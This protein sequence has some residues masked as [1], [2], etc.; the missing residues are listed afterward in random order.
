ML[1][2][3]TVSFSRSVL[4]IAIISLLSGCGG[5]SRLDP[6]SFLS[7]DHDDFSNA[8]L[9]IV[10]ESAVKKMRDFDESA[11]FLKIKQDYE[12]I[13]D[14][15]QNS[16][17]KLT[18]QQIKQLPEAFSVIGLNEEQAD[19]AINETIKTQNEINKKIDSWNNELV[20][21]YKNKLKNIQNQISSN[22]NKIKNWEDQIQPEK[23]E[24]NKVREALSLNKK[25]KKLL[26]E[27][28][29]KEIND[30]IVENNI[31]VNIA[32]NYPVLSLSRFYKSG[33]FKKCRYNLD[34]Q[35]NCY[36][37][38]SRNYG[39]L[40]SKDSDR[41]QFILD[42]E[43]PKY[44]DLILKGQELNDS[45]E[46]LETQFN[47]KKI[48]TQNNFGNYN[49]LIYKKNKLN[50]ELDNLNPDELFKNDKINKN[51]SIYQ[52]KYEQK[53]EQL[54]FSRKTPIQQYLN[55]NRYK[56]NEGFVNALKDAAYSDFSRMFENIDISSSGYFDLPKIEGNDDYIAIVDLG[57]VKDARVKTVLFGISGDNPPKELY[58]DS[59]TRVTNESMKDFITTDLLRIR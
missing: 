25:Q 36:K 54:G 28:Y 14:V 53:L 21:E 22:N 34:K 16:L 8:T 43:I 45:Y 1:C 51:S 56:I 23:I 48:I 10:K 7:K 39:N 11:S 17:E 59:N 52:I 26:N 15:R 5:D 27:N 32:G 29:R 55:N 20:N 35:G 6:S 38:S 33:T 30:F 41:I 47:N 19:R 31:P 2:C 49:D 4:S 37:L 24:L 42:K 18:P 3:K 58:N 9:Q 13:L 46:L 40:S 44:I 57:K 12:L 50:S